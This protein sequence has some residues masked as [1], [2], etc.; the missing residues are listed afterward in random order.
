[1]GNKPWELKPEYKQRIEEYYEKR[2][3]GMDA[4]QLTI[5][6]ERL[7]WRLQDK[8]LSAEDRERL[9]NELKS[10]QELYDKAGYGIGLGDTDREPGDEGK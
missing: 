3:E 9:E 5:F 7:K 2:S 10:A 1:M 4:T 6:M 8:N